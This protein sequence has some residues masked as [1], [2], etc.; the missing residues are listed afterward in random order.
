MDKG[1]ESRFVERRKRLMATL[2]AMESGN[3]RTFRL[4]DGRYVA[5]TQIAVATACETLG[6]VER[7]LER[8]GG[9]ADG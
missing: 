2:G 8:T 4:S 6:A 9:A 7:V 1:R 3:L 5:T